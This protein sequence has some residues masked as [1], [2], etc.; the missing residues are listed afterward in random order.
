[1]LFCIYMGWYSLMLNVDVCDYKNFNVFEDIRFDFLK[2]VEFFFVY[3]FDFYRIEKWFYNGV[4][5]VVVFFIYVGYCINIY[6]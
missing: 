5:L 3:E 2:W 6:Y 4:V 1:M